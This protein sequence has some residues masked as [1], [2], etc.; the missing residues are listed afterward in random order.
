M[1]IYLDTGFFVDYFSRRSMIAVKLRTE[2]RRGRSI[3]KIQEDSNTIMK[4]LD[5]HKAITSVLTILEYKENTFSELKKFSR[6]L[7]D[8]KI[9][10]IMKNKTEAS[11]LYERCQRNNIQLI[12]LNS[13]ILKEAL[14]N[15]EYNE[16]EIN[17]A[18]HIQTAR[19]YKA[20]VVVSTDSGLLK[21]DGLFD[22]IRIVD[23]DEALKLL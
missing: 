12:S 10:N 15:Q 23:T 13:Q 8:I 9:E 21:F 20:E 18:I 2:S 3:Q 11:T 16:L 7:D 17:D 14:T 5:P 19:A 6:G 22:N 4:K 1:I